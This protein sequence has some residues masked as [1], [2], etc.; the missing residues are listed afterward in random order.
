MAKLSSA[1]QAKSIYGNVRWMSPELLD[2]ERFGFLDSRPTEES[3]CYALGMV[4]LEV[5]SGRAP[6]MACRD[7]IVMR[8]VTEGTH[9]ERPEEAWFTDEVWRTL[10]RFWTPEPLSRPR[11]K[12]MFQCL[13]AASPS[14]TTLSHLVSSTANS[15]VGELIKQDSVVTPN[16]SQVPSASWEITSQSAQDP[17]MH[18]VSS[19]PEDDKQVSSFI[20]PPDTALTLPLH[21]FLLLDISSVERVF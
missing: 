4:V 11:V 18:G 14:W 17:A 21:C 16:V 7:A 9:P 13:E 1:P 20:Y 15:S 5:L 8:K 3:D 2:P 19:G 6:F 10:E 12:V